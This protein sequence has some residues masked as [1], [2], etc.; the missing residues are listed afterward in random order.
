MYHDI[1]TKVL[2][3]KETELE[4]MGE[5][6][7]LKALTL[8]DVVNMQPSRK[9]ELTRISAPSIKDMQPTEEQKLAK[10]K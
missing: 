4:E 9:E 6:E 10:R 1:L 3:N 2:V 5:Q 8:E 7:A